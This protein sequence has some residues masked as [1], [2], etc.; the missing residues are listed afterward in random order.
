MQS[1]SEFGNDAKL[2]SAAE[3]I[4]ARDTI[5][6]HLDRLE[7]KNLMKIDKSSCTW[8]CIWVRTISRISTGWRM[9]GFESNPMDEGL[10]ILVDEKWDMSWQCALAPKKSNFMVLKE[11]WPAGQGVWSSSPL[12]CFCE[13]TLGVLCLALGPLTKERHG[14]VGVS[15]KGHKNNQR[16]GVPLPWGKT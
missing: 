13:T 12:L 9:N 7:K 15:E 2:T 16:A 6:R 3:G 4:E 8:P 11:A 10:R 5:Q 1:L 14:P